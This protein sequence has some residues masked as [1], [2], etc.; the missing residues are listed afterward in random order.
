MENLRVRVV[1]QRVSPDPEQAAKEKAPKED[2]LMQ[3]TIKVLP[4][5]GQLGFIFTFKVDFQANYFMMVE[6]DYTS[7]FFADQLKKVLSYPDLDQRSLQSPQYEVDFNKRTLIRKFNKKY[8]FEAQLPFEVKK[9]I[10]LKNVRPR[11]SLIVS[12]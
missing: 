6:T 1:V 9:S 10:S 8:K 4:A 3:E 12:L 7:N 11:F 2:V 5:R